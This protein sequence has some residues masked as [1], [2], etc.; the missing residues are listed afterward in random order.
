MTE[1]ATIFGD[2]TRQTHTLIGG[3]TG[4]G[5]SVVIRGILWAL[6]QHAPQRYKML[7]I[8]PK[9]VELHPYRRAP[10]C[11]AYADTPEAMAAAIADMC[12]VMD[13][14]YS[15]MQAREMRETVEPH[16]YII[17]DELADLMDVCGSGCKRDLKRI[18]QLGRAAG[19]HVIA[20]TQHPERRVLPA[21]IQL[22]FTAVLALPCKTAIESRQL[23]GKQ[24]AERLEIGSAYYMSCSQ[25]DPA[26]VSI[27]MISDADLRAAVER[28][29][30]PPKPP[31]RTAY[32]ITPEPTPTRPEPTRKWGFLAE[33]IKNILYPK[34]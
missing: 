5:K 27:P 14:R 31:Q 17:I 32:K 26:R 21:E 4:A 19:I 11:T 10:H 34:Y 29:A 16:I 33:L 15:E 24:G 7:L 8:D 9:R 25:R 12:R 2:I 22:N 6:L 20:A 28:W 1:N 23:I 3:M 13:D 30:A 18:L